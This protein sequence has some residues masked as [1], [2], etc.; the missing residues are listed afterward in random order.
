MSLM[1]LD[2][3][4]WSAL[5]LDACQ[6]ADKKL[7]PIRPAALVDGPLTA[8]AAQELGLKP[9]IPV[10]VGAG[11]DVEIIGAGLVQPGTALEHLGTTGSLLMCTDHLAID[12][13]SG[14]EIYPHLVPG[15]WVLGGSTSSAGAALK[16]AT[17]I[18]AVQGEL[19]LAE[20]LEQPASHAQLIFLPYLAGERS[21]IWDP[22]ARGTFFGLS[23]GHQ[24][25][26]VIRS[27]F[28]GVA[29]SLHHVLDAMGDL[30]VHPTTVRIAGELAGDQAWTQLRAN[31]YGV[32]L[33]VMGQ[34]DPTAL[35]AMIVGAV[36][37]G[38]YGD[39]SEAIARIVSVHEVVLP[40]DKQA[41]Y[42]DS[43]YQSYRQISSASLSLSG[44]FAAADRGVAMASGSVSQRGSG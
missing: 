5:L 26:D 4:Q 19:S 38:L 17:E 7:P 24:R 8:H 14:L 34:S 18:F 21:P 37:A 11:D 22:H 1:D 3:G 6:I 27:V 30:G 36:A 35:G 10:A 32:P 16:W 23:L 13:T 41:A 15:L 25:H 33:V 20:L 31:V 39:L 44:M 29:F 40:D 9:G 2:R 43:L 42:Y 12:W 28:E